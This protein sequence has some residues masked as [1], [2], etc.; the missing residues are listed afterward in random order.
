[1]RGQSR[2]L[3]LG[4]AVALLAV[5][6][7]VGGGALL[8]PDAGTGAPLSPSPAE[9]VRGP[10]P[11]DAIARAQQR[12]R[13]VPADYV[14]WAELGQSYVQQA[15]ITADPTYYPRAQ[16][17]L[18]RSLAVHPADNAPAHVGLAALAAARHD[19]AGALAEGRRALAVDAYSAPA[20]GIVGD[21]L[22]ELGRYPEAY[23]AIQRMSDLAPGTS[24][25]ARAS[26]TFELRGDLSHAR[27]TLEMALEVA[28]SPDD[29]GFALYYL[30]ELAWN[31]GD[32]PAARARYDEGLRRAPGYL[33]LQEGRA[34][35]L[36]A[37]GRTAEAV[38]VYR[39]LVARLPQPAYVVEL[40][41]LLAATGDRAGARQ[42]YALVRAEERILVA[43]GV[44]VDLEL[45]LFEADHGNPAAA[46]TAARKT[47]ALRR[48]VFA[49]DALAWALHAAGRDAEA[50]PHARAA[51][52]LGTHSAPLR[53]H[54]GMI[55]RAL[56]DRAGARRDL[57]AAL[58]LNPHF[59]VLQAPVARRA[60]RELR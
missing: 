29:A 18:D 7:L 24:S 42:Q 47:Y 35:V 53:Y 33:P 55:S 5:V 38:A 21:A 41:D 39:S 25:Y 51:Q 11:G 48:G 37:E 36:A 14:T 46:L 2:T 60:L 9:R 3:A 28:P 1:M 30:G 59:S 8:R 40:G 56:G 22:V 32:L 4:A 15:R 16:G 57:T 26:Y 23:R 43:N 17:A 54:L 50:L 44:D 31:A 27:R 12:L 49:E 10:R 52:R 13:E 20:Y 58:E 34:K 19:F 45:A 6:L